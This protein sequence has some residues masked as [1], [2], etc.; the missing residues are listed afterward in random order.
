MAEAIVRHGHAAD[1]IL[2]EIQRL[3]VD[4]IVMRTHG[5]AGIERSILGSVTEQILKQT[6]VPMILMRPAQRRVAHVGKVLLAVDGSPGSGGA[7]TTAAALA[8]RTAASIHVLQVVVPLAMRPMVADTYG[9]SYYD[10]AW[11]EDTVAAAKANVHTVVARLRNSGVTAAGETYL[12]AG[13]AESVTEAAD[14]HAVDLVVMSTRGLTGT[15]RA[16]LGSVSDAVVRTAH[17]PVLLV[18]RTEAAQDVPA[19]ADS[20]PALRAG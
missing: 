5:R 10:P 6:Q 7:V 11:D 14:R 1:Q 19:P 8:L 16:V 17:C 12:A 13:V 9:I 4:L 15:A 20:T 2:A 3:P 18:H